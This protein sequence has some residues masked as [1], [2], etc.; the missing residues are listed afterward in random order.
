MRNIIPQRD[1]GDNS[2][3]QLGGNFAGKLE[4]GAAF[5]QRGVRRNEAVQFLLNTAYV[6]EMALRFLMIAVQCVL[7]MR[8]G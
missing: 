5:P 4:H 7:T 2:S 6:Q 3:D 8:V 1:A